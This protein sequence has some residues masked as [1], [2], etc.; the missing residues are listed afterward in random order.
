MLTDE[1]E[2]DRGSRATER[3][4]G[5]AALQGERD[6]VGAVMRPDIQIVIKLQWAERRVH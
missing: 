3:W 6:Y 1:S 2:T 4:G 5:D